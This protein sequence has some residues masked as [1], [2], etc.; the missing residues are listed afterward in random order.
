M[1]VTEAKF[2]QPTIEGTVTQLADHMPSGDAWAAKSVEDSDLHSQVH[3]TAK[4]FN[5]VQGRIED[6]AREFD[7]N[8]TV[9]LIDD[10][11]ESVDLPDDCLGP[12]SDIAERRA[13]VIER[14]AKTPIVTLAEQQ[15]YIDRLF[16]D[17][18]ITLIPGFDFFSFEYS[19]EMFFLGN[20]DERFIIVALIPPQDPFFEYD[21]E[22][23]FTGGVDQEDLLCVL[24]R[25]TP[26][27]VLPLIL[28][29][30]V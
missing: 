2:K 27:N 26:A 7:I 22:L 8:Q 20:V 25:I 19:L 30:V 18:D 23:D 5:I 9:E 29:G 3:G 1:S 12:S 28:E 6:L 21:L 4:P 10:W 15:A 14:L 13:A 16:P 11:E 24:N 17:L